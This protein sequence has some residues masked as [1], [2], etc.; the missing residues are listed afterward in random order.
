MAS[1]PSIDTWAE[2]WTVFAWSGAASV[3]SQCMLYLAFR[4]SRYPAIANAAALAAHQV[5]ALAF[6]LIAAAVGGAAWWGGYLLDPGTASGRLLQ[7]NG[8]AR[9]LASVLGGELVLWDLPVGLFVSQLRSVDSLLHHIGMAAVC[10]CVARHLPNY[11]A[12]YYLG[13]IELSSIPLQLNDFCRLNRAC[14]EGPDAVPMLVALNGP[15][16]LLTAVGFLLIRLLSF[17]YVTLVLCIP[18]SL[19]AL[20]EAATAEGGAH[21]AA[22]KV[23]IVLLSA[24]EALQLYW[25]WLHGRA[26]IRNA[27]KE[28]KRE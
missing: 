27:Q 17:S 28:K 16:Q 8:T 20:P 13:A 6:M 10:F 23:L 7:S 26:F 14:V 15:N 21:E 1:L 2:A 18:D 5:I 11:Y 22:L 25:G 3:A 9:W 12:V 4:Q 19:A 24:F